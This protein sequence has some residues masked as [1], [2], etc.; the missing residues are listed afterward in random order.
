MCPIHFY[1][2]YPQAGSK[3]LFIL[4]GFAA[5]FSFKYFSNHRIVFNNN[6]NNSDND[7]D[8]NIKIDNNDIINISTI[9]K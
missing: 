8:Y 7:N 2:L 4:V 1:D 5:H 3:V 9:L 6:D